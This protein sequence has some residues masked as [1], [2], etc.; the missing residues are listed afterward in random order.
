MSLSRLSG[1]RIL[2][3]LLVFSVMIAAVGILSTVQHISA[4]S[5]GTSNPTAGLVAKPVISSVDTDS[6]ATY[7]VS[8]LMVDIGLYASD[9]VTVD[10]PKGTFGITMPDV[11]AGSLNVRSSGQVQNIAQSGVLNTAIPTADGVQLLTELPDRNAP[12]SYSYNVTGGVTTVTKDGGAVVIDD[13]GN[14]IMRAA[15]AWAKD[16]AGR[17][18]PTHYVADGSRLIQV[19]DHGS[20]QFVYPIVADPWWSFLTTAAMAACGYQILDIL[21]ENAAKQLFLRGDPTWTAFVDDSLEDCLIAFMFW[22]AGKVV[23]SALKRATIRAL[24]P[25]MV[26]LLREAIKRGA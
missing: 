4:R 11:S 8:D 22:G 16:A 24:K 26:M 21:E 25:H 12:Q 17:N 13:R 7:R 14:V 15:P 20:G 10:G 1:W 18:V 19:V 3:C 9:G 6:V 5:K 23:H 2:T